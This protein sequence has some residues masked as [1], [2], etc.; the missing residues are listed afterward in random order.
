LE[1][2]LLM[3]E[4]QISQSFI[5]SREAISLAKPV[6][7]KVTNARLEEVLNKCFEGQPLIYQVEGR[8]IIIKQKTVTS[9]PR[10]DGLPLRGRV[11]SENNQPL[12]GI[13]VMIRSTNEVAVTNSNGEF[14]FKQF[15]SPGI[16]VVSGAE[17]ELMELRAKAG[18]NLL[19]TAKQKVGVL[20]ETMVI[21]Y[22]K[23]TRRMNTGNVG[24]VKGEEIRKQVVSNPLTALA[25]RIPGL[26]IRQ[27]SG[28]PGA[29]MTVELRG[30]N[31][32]ANGN[33]PLYVI[34]G[35]PFPS[36]SLTTSGG[37]G[38]ITS[39]FN[40][41][42]PYDIESIEVL[43]D[44]EATSIYGSRGA[45]GVI[46]IT[47]KRGKSGKEQINLNTYY[48]FG[49]ILKKMPLLNT[50]Q[51]LMMR[52]EAF[53]NDGVTPTTSNARDLLVWDT[54]RYTDWQD[55]FVGN[56]SRVYDV[57]LNI[58]GGSAN[59]QYLLGLGHHKETS[60]FPGDFFDKKYSALFSFNH[61]ST[62]RRLSLMAQVSFI[63]GENKLPQDNP[64][65]HITLPPNAPALYDS[66]GKYNWANSTWTN[67]AASLEK[68][69]ES[70]TDNLIASVGMG[71][72]VLPVLEF[73]INFGFNSIQ[74]KE[75]LITPR[76][77]VNPA[78]PPSALVRSVFGD[79]QVRS[80][81][82]EPQLEL[83]KSIRNI[84]FTALAGSTLQSSRRIAT[85]VS[86]TGFSSDELMNNPSAAADID[87][88]RGV[89]DIY[90]YIA[91]FGRLNM[92]YNKRY[93][94][95]GSFRYDGS[96]RFGPGRRFAGFGS[97]GLGWIF[98]QTD[99]VRRNVEFLNFG[100]LRVSYGTTGNDQIGEYNY[101]DT[102][103]NYNYPYQGISTLYPTRLSNDKYGWEMVK[104]L[105]GGLELGFLG[106][107]VI[108][109]LSYFR[110]TT[111]NQL[112]SY[113][114]PVITGFSGVIQNIPAV[115]RNTG[116]EIDLST[117][118]VRS[119]QF[120][121]KANFNLT[122]PRNKLVDYPDL[123]ASSYAN[124]YVIGRSLFITKQYHYL[125]VNPATGLYEFEDFNEDN[126]ISSP[127]DRQFIVFTGQQ[128]FGGLSQN[129]IW[130][131]LNLNFLIQ[132][133]R[134]KEIVSHTNAFARAGSMV[135]QPIYVLDRWQHPGDIS[136]VQRFST[137]NS[138]ATS[139]DSRFDQSDAGYTDGSFIRGKSIYLGY[140]FNKT[141]GKSPIRLT[142]YGQLQNFFT[143][144]RYKVLDPETRL[145]VAP[146]KTYSLG[147]NLT[148]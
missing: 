89:E 7:I 14:F 68:T 52:R 118:L 121:W 26:N 56:T 113:P 99:W 106:N 5:Y 51:Y 34:D 95:S 6:T 145:T 114:L 92:T 80:T 110:N 8:H 81:V 79:D 11:L 65:Q 133:V 111:A 61:A 42:N 35:V 90:H 100:K 75:R 136:N 28:M 129:I 86:A 143:I 2:V 10:E 71:Y 70:W 135:N 103:S 55:Y 59:T 38:T 32:I 29:Y 83:K 43:K 142:L 63:A 74:T 96:S 76:V 50:Q 60:V 91:F 22:G 39:P 137:S 12:P 84:D 45:N 57:H 53:A 47:T 46:L 1:R 120:N 132:F 69:F 44:A 41:I 24:Q 73:K 19:V 112:L 49:K 25:G 127:L 37:G 18:E 102:Y 88:F 62:D 124:S 119:S 98:T 116:V 48:G 128:Y 109:N 139:A 85:A 126:A 108:L 125:G 20:D 94:L 101:L 67:P 13:S 78:F 131:R 104:K 146:Q 97:V 23:T 105:E 64:R 115:I 31:S 33:D 87:L 82:L 3:I 66:S 77:S 107:A 15:P 58:S 72:K 147:I 27:I 130:K 138:A 144:S 134:Q 36:S 122:V 140:E 4:R 117:T 54:T 40:N 17:V 93:L 30:Q 141:K 123:A 148:L 21:A 9:P 16:I